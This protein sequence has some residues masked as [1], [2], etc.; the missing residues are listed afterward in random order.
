MK[1]SKNVIGRLSQLMLAV[2][3]GGLIGSFTQ[4]PVIAIG[5]FSVVASPAIIA[6]SNPKGALLASINI[7]ELTTVLGAYCR[8]NR[9]ILVQ[10]IM[11]NE[12]DNN[13]YNVLE[14]VTDEVA[15]PSLSFGADIV[16]PANP[17]QFQPS[18]DA[19]LLGAR[20]LKARGCKVDVLLIPQILEK[21]WLGKKKKSND[22]FDMPL[23]QFI[24]NGLIG[25]AKQNISRNAMFKG[26]YNAAGTTSATTMDGFDTILA[27]EV[28]ASNPNIV[29]VTTGAITSANI[30]A[31][32]LLI[33]DGLS[34]D[35]KAEEDLVCDLCPT[36]FDW[37]ARMFQPVVNPTLVVTDGAAAMKFPRVTEISLPGTNAILRRNAGKAISAAIFFTPKENMYKGVDSSV[38]NIDIQ[39][40]DRTI[41]VLMDFKVGV[42]FAQ[43]KN[44]SLSCNIPV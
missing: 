43:F 14:D 19:V 7:T 34:E 8:E 21:S 30:L 31:K 22:P 4:S 10:E 13:K 20:I 6:I 24:M 9:D 3:I 40:A 42:N 41:K 28:A 15:L 1:Q 26:V 32:L 2:L 25:K 44:G 23:E 35:A 29:P 36:H 5:V 37:V 33:H 11:L 27:A 18:D 16:K 39:K 38:F 12:D 17:L